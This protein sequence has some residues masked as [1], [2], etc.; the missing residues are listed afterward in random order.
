MDRGVVRRSKKRGEGGGR[1]A[2]G[3]HFGLAPAAAFRRASHSSLGISPGASGQ[4][5]RPQNWVCPA[6]VI[7]FLHTLLVYTILRCKVVS[8]PVAAAFFL[9]RFSVV[10]DAA[11]VLTSTSASC[12][13]EE[14]VAAEEEE[15]PA[16]EEAEE[17]WPTAALRTLAFPVVSSGSLKRCGWRGEGGGKEGSC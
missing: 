4:Y 17:G 3:H 7:A 14:A 6:D 16:D 12:S 8:L 1:G 13:P 9:W 10:L 15:V 2:G 11:V 5:H